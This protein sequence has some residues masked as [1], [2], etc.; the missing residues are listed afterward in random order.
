VTTVSPPPFS[1]SPDF[2]KLT[3]PLAADQ[4]SAQMQQ[5]N[6][7]AGAS[8]FGPGQDPN[9]MFLAEA[10]NLEVAGGTHEWVIEGVE[11]RVLQ[12]L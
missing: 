6:P 9:K 3:H 12:F 4:M 7:A 10:E 11:G 2:V 8:M 1:L 5:M